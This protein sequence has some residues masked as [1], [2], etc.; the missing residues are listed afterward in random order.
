MY[1]FYPKKLPV[2]FDSYFQLIKKVHSYN[3]RLSS[4]HALPK[5][6]TNYGIFNI[7]F[8]GA[9]MWNLLGASVKSLSIKSFKARLGERFIKK[10]LSFKI[11]K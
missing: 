2:V 4:K 8:T 3:T 9:K 11:F 10:L 6:R 1:N 5:A 7:K